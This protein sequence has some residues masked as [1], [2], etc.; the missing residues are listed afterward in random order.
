MNVMIYNY[1]CI[2]SVTL[3]CIFILLALTHL[4]IFNI[5]IILNLYIFVHRFIYIIYY[6]FLKLLI[7]LLGI[8]IFFLNFELNK[9]E[10]NFFLFN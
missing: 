1:I 2:E 7:L 5:V 8:I 6:N 9:T 4:S 3:L 10:Y